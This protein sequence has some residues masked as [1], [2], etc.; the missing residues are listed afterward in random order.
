MRLI[1]ERNYINDPNDA[2]DIEYTTPNYRRRVTYPIKGNLTN[3]LDVKRIFFKI[4]AI[5]A[6]VKDFKKLSK[7]KFCVLGLRIRNFDFR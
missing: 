6:R 5:F 7:F 2:T 4:L 1:P 3:P